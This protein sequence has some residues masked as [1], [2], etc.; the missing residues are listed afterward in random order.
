MKQF[1]AIFL[2]NDGILVDTEKYHVEACDEISRELF[3]LPFSLKKY[4][5]YGYT[6]GIGIQGWLA[7]QGI[8]DKK[9]QTFR[10]IRDKRYAKKLLQKIKPLPGVRNFLEFCKSR[11]ILTA[12]VTA[13]YEEHFLQIHQQT[14]LLPYFKFWI[15]HDD[16][17]KRKPSSEGYLLAAKKMK[18][19]PKN[20]LVIED[21]PRGIRAGKEAGMTVYAIPTGQTKCLNLSLSDEKFAEF[22]ELIKFLEK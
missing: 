5:E 14:G 13:S 11:E 20:C 19:N 7:E 16:V 22:S 2:D 18:V 9:I 15:T 12:V 6:K 3:G 17:A 21:S 4:Q 8:S 1:E 10:K